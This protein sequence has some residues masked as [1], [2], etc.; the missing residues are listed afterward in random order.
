MRKC[1]CGESSLAITP[2]LTLLSHVQLILKD[3]RQVKLLI[4]YLFC[5]GWSWLSSDEGGSILFMCGST[6]KS[7]A[8]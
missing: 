2:L 4:Q 5:V 3:E 1:A 7:G 8:K 6:E